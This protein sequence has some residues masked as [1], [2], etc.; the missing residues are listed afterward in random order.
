MQRVGSVLREALDSFDTR[1]FAHQGEVLDSKDVVA[2]K[3]RLS[4]ARELIGLFGLKPSVS[5]SNRG[6]K[7]ISVDV[8]IHPGLTRK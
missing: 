5:R 6:G 2:W 1:F 4:A 7:H 8:E 3:T